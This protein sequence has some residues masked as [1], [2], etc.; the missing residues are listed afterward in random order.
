MHNLN[1]NFDNYI[2]NTPCG[3]TTMPYFG[4]RVVRG[5]NLIQNLCFLFL[6]FKIKIAYLCKSKRDKVK[7]IIEQ[8]WNDRSLLKESEV[9]RTIREV[10]DN[11]IISNP[12]VVK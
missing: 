5:S 1:R 8:A 11:E 3:S 6:F 4:K 9:A 10:I 7:D 12:K 2:I